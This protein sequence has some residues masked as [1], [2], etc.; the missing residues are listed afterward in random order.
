MLLEFCSVEFS[1]IARY[2]LAVGN[3]RSGERDDKTAVALNL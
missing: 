1:C 2:T 3:G